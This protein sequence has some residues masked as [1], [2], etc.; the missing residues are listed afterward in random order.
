MGDSNRD[1]DLEEGRNVQIVVASSQPEVRQ[2]DEQESARSQK[3]D[4][5]QK[6]ENLKEP[7]L[8]R[9][10]GTYW[11]KWIYKAKFPI[12]AIILIW[13]GIAV[14]RAALLEPAS[15]GFKNFDDDHYLIRIQD[16]L[17]N[18]FHTSEND[19]TIQVNFIWGVAGV[20]NDDTDRWDPSDLGTVIWDDNFD[21]SSEAN[22]QRLLDICNDL[23]ASSLV[24]DQQV[25]C[26]V[27]NFLNARNGGNPVAQA[28]FYTELDAYLLTTQGQNEYNDNLIGYI[29]GRL[30]FIK[31][32]ALSVEA[33]F[34]GRD[35]L[36]PVYNDWDDL[37]DTYNQ[38]SLAGVNYAF[39]TAGLH[40]C[41][42]VTEQEFVIGAYQGI[43]ISLAFAF[44][45]LLLSTMNILTALYSVI[46]I[47]GIIVSVIALMEML[48][49]TLGVIE[50]VAVVILIGFSVDYV[51]HLANHYVESPFPDRFRRMKEALQGIG[52]SIFSGAATTFGCGFFLFF[53]TTIFFQKFAV[54][55]T[56]TILLSLFYSLVVFTAINH[57]IG[58]QNK[59]G[60]FR[61]YVINPIVRKLKEK[62]CKK[63]AIEDDTGE[64][65]SKGGKYK[66]NGLNNN[67]RSSNQ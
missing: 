19:N 32:Q 8:E 36:W 7:L 66:E 9:F 42:L 4:A 1:V 5:Q 45:V 34:Q 25:T 28:N 56:S 39:Q 10:F 33:P 27:E 65:S 41:M 50:S 62:C 23:K 51:V 37:K 55:I 35:K 21:M 13:F 60:D 6:K 44:V 47:G 26:W 40:W 18:G 15:E 64:E 54:L 52:I 16:M 58:P 11:N 38:G 57:W 61:Y 49:W 67:S 46:S 22:Q 30:Y 59:V 43:A 3:Q 2:K 24:K 14:W 29:G 31:I 48:G 53:A 63:K 20:D 12:L 17:R